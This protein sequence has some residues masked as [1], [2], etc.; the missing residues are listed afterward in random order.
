MP[1]TTEKFVKGENN[2]K[3]KNAETL[4]K[5]LDLLFFWFTFPCHLIPRR[6]VN[7]GFIRHMKTLIKAIASE[8][9]RLEYAYKRERS[10]GII[11]S[12][13]NNLDTL[14][15]ELPSG[16]GIDSGCKI[17]LDN[18]TPEKIIITFGFHHMDENGSYDGWTDHKLTVKPSFSGIDIKISGRDRNQIKD[19]LY[20]V[21]QTVLTGAAPELSFYPIPA[22]P[23]EPTNCG[24]L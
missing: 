2:R 21:F 9:S 19:Y 16:S 5:S 13:K 24:V 8:I 7:G 3:K 22:A 15:D 23:V 18:S 17:D 20:D 6:P 14:Q 4:K 10:Q 12:A 1:T 11:D